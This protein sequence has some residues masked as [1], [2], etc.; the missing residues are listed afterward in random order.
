[1]GYETKAIFVS[2]HSGFK[3]YCSVIA[4]LDMGK[5]ADGHIYDLIGKAHSTDSKTLEARVKEWRDRHDYIFNAEGNYTDEL[6]KMSEEDKQKEVDKL[7]EMQHK[8]D[9]RLPYIFET[10]NH[11][12]DYTDDYGELMMMVDLKDFRSAVVKENKVLIAKGI[13]NAPGYRR[14]VMAIRMIDMFDKK[15]WGEE[16]VKVILWGH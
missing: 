5:I 6:L 15:I 12:H 3:G 7:F 16:P 10:S 8:L 1:M 14:F 13:Y 9:E 4:T 2:S 11:V